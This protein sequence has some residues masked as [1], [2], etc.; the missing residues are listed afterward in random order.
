MQG[1]TQSMNSRRDRRGELLFVNIWMKLPNSVNMVSYVI[2]QEIA[3]KIKPYTHGGYIKSCFICAS[4][5]LFRNFKD[6]TD[7]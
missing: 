7:I 6:K 1:K 3:Q 2:N 5:M 4:E